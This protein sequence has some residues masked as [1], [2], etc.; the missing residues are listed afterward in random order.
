MGTKR[1]IERPVIPCCTPAVQ[2][3][4]RKDKSFLKH[5]LSQLSSGTA[6][7]ASPVACAHHGNKSNTL[8]NMRC[9]PAYLPL[10]LCKPTLVFFF[11]LFYF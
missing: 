1:P 5:V 7:H 3:S 6:V 2:D 4:T 9:V 8:F 10:L 11:L